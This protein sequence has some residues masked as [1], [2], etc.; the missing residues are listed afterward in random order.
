MTAPLPISW[1]LPFPERPYSM[2]PTVSAPPTVLPGPTTTVTT[3]AYPSVVAPTGQTVT[4][5]YVI[6]GAPTAGVPPPTI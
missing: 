3:T 1:N 2:A 4:E 6:S 5:T